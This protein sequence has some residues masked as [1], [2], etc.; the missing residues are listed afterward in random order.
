M[1]GAEPVFWSRKIKARNACGEIQTIET[2]IEG[3]L[4]EVLTLVSVSPC[5]F[6]EILGDVCRQLSHSTNNDTH[7]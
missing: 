4:N 1:L 3:I 7:C 2:K 6:G 5:N